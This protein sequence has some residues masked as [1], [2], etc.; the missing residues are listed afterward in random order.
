MRLRLRTKC[1]RFT[2]T[3]QSGY[4]LRGHLEGDYFRQSPDMIF[5]LRSLNAVCLTPQ[6]TPL[7]YCNEVFGQLRL[8]SPEVILSGSQSLPHSHTPSFFSLNYRDEE[9]TIY[10]GQT[11]QW[12]ATG[13][14]PESWQVIDETSAPA[15][16]RYESIVV[17][18]GW[19]QRAIA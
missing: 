12:L 13:W 1:L 18:T 11:D 3:F 10:D 7:M 15:I 4:Q 8:A 5:N 9:A 16:K 6:G 17:P 14:S 2:Y 19:S